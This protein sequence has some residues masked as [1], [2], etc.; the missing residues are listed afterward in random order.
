M[1]GPSRDLPDL[2]RA[3]RVVAPDLL[4]IR[5]SHATP[6]GVVTLRLTEVE[7][8]EGERDPGSHAARGRTARNASM[9]GPPGTVYVYRHL[10]IHHCLNVV[11]GDED[12]AG[13][14]LLRGAEVVDGQ[15][16][17]TR[18]R[19]ASGVVRSARDLARGPGRLASALGVD[20]TH[21]GL[22]LDVDQMWL[23]GAPLAERTELQVRSGPRVGVPGVGGDG[24]RFPWRWWIEGEPTVS[25]YRRATPRRLR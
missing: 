8:Y 2:R 14:V 6:E 18:R 7:A 25:A 16:L 20:L 23:R 9:Y 5:L 12:V 22:V 4:G 10:G 13:A 3:P 1:S 19:A 15:D 11:C 17:A 24:S 21:D